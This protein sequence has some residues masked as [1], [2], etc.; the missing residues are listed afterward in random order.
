MPTL[1]IDNHEVT[2]PA[3]A[4]VLDAARALGIDV[5][6]LCQRDGCTP[7]TSCLCCVVR[8]NGGRRLVPSCATKAADGMVVESETAEIRA[9]RKTALE[10]LLADHAGDCRA[11]CQNVCPARMDIPTMIRQIHD[12]ALHEALITVKQHIALPAV[13][14]RI[15][16]ELCEKGCRR[17]QLDSPVS[18]CRLKRHVADVDLA[19]EKPWLPECHHQSGKRVAIVGSGP[20]GLAAAWYLLQ[21]GHACTLLDEHDEPGG[22]LRYAVEPS[23]L[24]RDVLDAEIGLVRQLGATFEHP[25]QVGKTTSVAEL[26]QQYDAVLLAVGEVDAVKANAL[27]VPM[28]GRGLKTDKRTMLTPTPGVFATGAAVTPYR[29][30]VRAVGDGRTAA[31][32]IDAFLRG[33]APAHESQFTVRLGVLSDAELAVFRAEATGDD[34]AGVPPALGLSDRPASTE[35]ARCL[36]CQCAKLNTCSLRK[37]SSAYDASPSEYK[38]ERRPFTRVTNHASIVYEPGKCI[39]CGL[40]VQ[41]ASRAAEPLGLT[42]IGRGFD[43]RI[44]VPFDHTISQALQHT[45]ESCA[46]ACPTGALVVRDEMA[47]C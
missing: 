16:P 24:P 31:A 29:H 17:G 39:S 19:S 35:S 43:V 34:R 32:S 44:G 4:S 23:R 10:L 3:G 46:N 41:I 20:A 6:A 8:V 25:V 13:L 45:A 11:P 27:G 26:S 42:F 14:G 47:P 37:Y 18:I 7:N 9:A 12:G 36:Q 30:A 2:V 22:N 40:C 38:L 28:L 15:C 21:L 5:P 33:Y 1:K